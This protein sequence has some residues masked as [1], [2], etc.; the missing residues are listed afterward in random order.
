MHIFG[1][2]RNYKLGL[3]VNH[4]SN[5]GKFA[6]KQLLA[7]L[8]ILGILLLSSFSSFADVRSESMQR[9]YGQLSR[10]EINLKEFNKIIQEKIVHEL[11]VY[12]EHLEN[13]INN[14]KDSKNEL[15]ASDKNWNCFY[16]G[17]EQNE[18]ENILR[19]AKTIS[20]KRK[21]PVV[22]DYPVEKYM[23]EFCDDPA[24]LRSIALN[25]LSE[26]KKL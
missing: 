15:V 18:L 13:V 19:D 7:G 20:G 21:L 4:Y 22:L 26:V 25:L 23:P 16:F 9:L 8:T 11:N 17:Q 10:G 24:R 1:K 14:F 3:H 2:Q 5:E 6:M 12:E